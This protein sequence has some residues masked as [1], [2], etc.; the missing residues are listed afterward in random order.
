MFQIRHQSIN[1]LLVSDYLEQI[2]ADCNDPKKNE[3]KEIIRSN[4]KKR[5]CFVLSIPIQE[6]KL[7]NLENEP[8]SHLKGEFL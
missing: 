7:K 6:D 5:D 8:I 3:I 1:N 4:F 2:L